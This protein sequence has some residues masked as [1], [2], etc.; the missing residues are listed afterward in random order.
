MIINRF[1]K[2]LNRSYDHT[3]FEIHTFESFLLRDA[4]E[5]SLSIF[6]EAYSMI[7]I[8][9]GSG[10]INI[11]MVKFAIKDDTVYYIKPGQSLIL[12]T[13][14]NAIGFIISFTR[15]F[16]ELYEKK[17]SELI[18]TALFNPSLTFPV[19][20][21]D[22]AMNNFMKNVADEM[23]QEFGNYYDLRL[24]I[25]KGLLKIFIIYLSRQ[26]ENE[27]QNN[28]QSRKMELVNNFY[29][30]LEKNF[31][32]KKQ[33]KEYAEVLAETP[34]YLNDI[35]KEISGFTASCHI[36]R[37]IVLEAKRR[38]IFE[39]YSL[40]EIA[41]HLGFWDPAHFSKYFKNSSG[42][43]FTD[44]KKGVSNFC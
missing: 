18:Q 20:R 12:E 1:A 13:D 34:N 17:T 11:D 37:R 27:F 6:D 33:V 39:G 4:D 29:I 8:R 28:F 25:L 16:V 31:T 26:F 40:K 30:Q 32:T 3:Q 19:I 21:I 2:N 22:K 23:V 42:I 10:E 36:Q 38:A 9:K 44:F 35:V 15:E 5:S 7:W 41:Y 43:N 14:D 24:E